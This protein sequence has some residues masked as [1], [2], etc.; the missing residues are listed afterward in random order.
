MKL[1]FLGCAIIL[2]LLSQ[3]SRAACEK[4]VARISVNSLAPCD[5]WIVKDSQMQEFAKNKDTLE[6]TKQLVKLSE[7]EV[8]FYKR[9]SYSQAVELEK[10]E[11][12]RFWSTAAGFTLG[13]ILTGV[14]AKAAIEVSR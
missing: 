11:T 9:R 6:L 5:G 12:R 13:V 7:T 1:F 10:A 3:L 14:A 2:L 8:E 4:D